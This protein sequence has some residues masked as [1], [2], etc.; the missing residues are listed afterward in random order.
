MS[1]FLHGCVWVNFGRVIDVIFSGNIYSNLL[2]VRLENPRPLRQPMLTA[3]NLAHFGLPT[4]I[5][6]P[7]TLTV[8]QH[9]NFAQAR[10]FLDQEGRLLSREER[11]QTQTIS[12]R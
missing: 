11:S 4:I 6:A 9:A 1:N 2:Q 12:S 3:P 5:R 8:H 7:S 10:P